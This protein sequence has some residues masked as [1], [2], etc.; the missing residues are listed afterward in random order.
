MSIFKK[1]AGQTLIY[2][3]ST[4]AARLLNF[5]LTPLFVNKFPVSIYGVFTNL[6][7][8]A[9]LINALLSFGMETTFFRFLNKQEENKTQVYNHSFSII[10]YLSL[11]FLGTVLLFINPITSFL[12]SILGGET[13][14]QDF[15]TYIFLFAL[16]L[17]ADAWAVIPFAKLRA[18]GKPGKFML[19]KI[20]NIL[21]FVGVN[22][23]FLIVLPFL[24]NA[25]LQLGDWYREGW[26]GYVFISNLIASFVTLLLLLPEFK[27]LKLSLDR[28]L[29]VK[30]IR[31]SFPILIANISFIINELID[32]MFMIPWLVPE[33]Q[34][35][36]DLGIY[37][38]VSKM[39][40]FLSIIVQGFRLGAEPFF[41][42]YAK[43]E[44]ARK[45]YAIIMDYFVIVVCLAMVGLTV[46]L[47]WLKYF[48]LGKNES[49]A[50]LIWSGLQVVPVLLL[51]YLF[52]GI[53]MNL[54][55]WYKLSDQ[56]QYALYI[57]LFGAATTLI[58]NYLFIPQFSYVAAAWAT[59]ASYFVMALLSY[60]WG[61]K[62]YPIPYKLKKNLGYIFFSA[63]LCWISMDL[64]KGHIIYGNALL[65][66]YL[67]IVIRLEYK[68]LLSLFK[69]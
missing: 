28:E 30:M 3:M 42:S 58:L 10:F 35:A 20:S 47:E 22:L 41:F 18:D 16:F 9:A 13:T 36:R 49:E 46:N 14:Y 40:I 38:A 4:I 67:S 11:L 17:V 69:S 1:F 48:I 39:A 29:T 21:T 51:A 60:A 52:L 37:G 33:E 43:N 5:I 27:H 44:N 19:V 63:L 23:F 61:Q 50:A 64:L 65:L 54:S 24:K 56:T 57:S 32:K 34:A 31:Y 53:Y 12:S 2:G 59:L 15:K 68:T 7:S 55:I 25:G 8:W 66:A 62:H 45:T 26:L 6:Y